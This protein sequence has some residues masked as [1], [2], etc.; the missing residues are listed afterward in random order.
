MLILYTLFFGFV[1]SFNIIELGNTKYVEIEAVHSID[2]PLGIQ[3][4]HAVVSISKTNLDIALKSDSV[5]YVPDQQ[6][7]SKLAYLTS[8]GWFLLE[9]S[10]Y[11]KIKRRA[12]PKKAPK[13]AQLDVTSLLR[14]AP[15]SL[16]N[17]QF[18]KEG[19]IGA[20]VYSSADQ[21]TSSFKKT[22]ED[23]QL[24]RNGNLGAYIFTEDTTSTSASE[25]LFWIVPAI[26]N[27]KVFTTRL[28]DSSLLL[29][30]GMPKLVK[31][32]I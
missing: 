18:I 16:E 23:A 8:Y 6:T 11:M 2:T 30:Y 21:P 12:Y 27:S 1:Y 3:I 19:T 20:Y 4:V 28:Q 13:N 7:F 25:S 29:Y 31:L 5:W 17:V 22:S 9:E 26:G 24:I 10:D 32:N 14:I 15:S